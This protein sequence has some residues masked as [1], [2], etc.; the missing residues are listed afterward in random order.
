M[1]NMIP[2]M[3]EILND[4]IIEIVNSLQ[5][6]GL[7]SFGSGEDCQREVRMVIKGQNKRFLQW[8]NCSVSW[9]WCGYTKSDKL[10]RTKYT[11]KWVQVMLDKF[12]WD[13]WIVSMSISWLWYCNIVTIG[14]NWMKGPQD[15]S[16]LFLT[17]P[18]DYN[19]LKLKV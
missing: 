5:L 13:Q 17:T 2:F 9:L 7:K 4:K 14:G 11:L 3:E 19:Y 12:E 18:W 10:C 8:W 1:Y 15:L 16:G 6:S